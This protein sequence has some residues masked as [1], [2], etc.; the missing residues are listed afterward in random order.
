MENQTQSQDV[1]ANE[2]VVVR[3]SS[4]PSVSGKSTITYQFGVVGEGHLKFR[5]TGNSGGGMFG[6]DWV[7]MVETIAILKAPENQEEIRAHAF[8]QL[9]LG[10]SINTQSFLLAALRHEGVVVV[11]PTK[12]RAYQVFEVKNFEDRMATLGSAS[13]EV[14]AE[15]ISAPAKPNKKQVLKAKKKTS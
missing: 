10:R 6:K 9:F 13:P 5:I 1:A 2:V 8:R 3:T 7:P 14:I 15:V 12:P 11:H 4:C